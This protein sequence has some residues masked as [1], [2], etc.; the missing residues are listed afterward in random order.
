MHTKKEN[1][2]EF[3]TENNQAYYRFKSLCRY[4]PNTTLTAYKPCLSKMAI[5]L[6]VQTSVT[7]I[8]I[9]DH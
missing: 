5:R 4:F 2:K 6:F 3:G 8:C 7:F 1:L 9:D